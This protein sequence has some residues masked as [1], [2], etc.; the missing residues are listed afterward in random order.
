M[1]RFNLAV[2]AMLL[3]LASNVYAQKAPTYFEG[4]AQ[5]QENVDLAVDQAK[6]ITIAS[7]DR[8]CSPTK[9][10]VA[11][12]WLVARLG[13]LISA[14]AGFICGES[15][16]GDVQCHRIGSTYAWEC[17]DASGCWIE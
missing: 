14:K 17:C 12:E 16:N 5:I 3:L 9:S 15:S 7:A 2:S 4:R 13:N 1:N 8:A 6:S 10:I 11:T